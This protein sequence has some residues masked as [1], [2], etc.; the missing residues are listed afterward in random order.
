MKE[1]KHPDETMEKPAGSGPSGSDRCPCGNAGGP[2]PV[3]HGK[4]IC[5]KCGLTRPLQRDI[6]CFK[7]PCPE[8]GTLMIHL[9]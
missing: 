1:R 2:P 9:S 6:P 4:C 3:P 7:V 5:P 8:C